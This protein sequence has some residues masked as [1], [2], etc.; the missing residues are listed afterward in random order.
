[1]DRHSRSKKVFRKK[2]S[3]DGV[4]DAVQQKN[5]KEQK[6]FSRIWSR[7]RERG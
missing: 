2:V 6:E 5:A 1:M 4:P 7:Y 3:K